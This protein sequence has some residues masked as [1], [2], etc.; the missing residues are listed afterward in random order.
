MHFFFFNLTFPFPNINKLE[1]DSRLPNHSH[2]IMLLGSRL[3]LSFRSCFVHRQ[4]TFS[5]KLLPLRSV[6]PTSI[7]FFL[8]FLASLLCCA[9]V[10]K[11]KHN[12]VKANENKAPKENGVD[13]GTQTRRKFSL[14]LETGSIR[15]R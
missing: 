11:A 2:S 4:P 8:H 6:E 1:L 7:I 15:L 14:S 10:T 5:V 3:S 9:V 13:T 12:R